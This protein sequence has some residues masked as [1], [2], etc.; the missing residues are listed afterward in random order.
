VTDQFKTRGP[1]IRAAI[2]TARG[3][4]LASLPEEMRKDVTDS[5]AKATAAFGLLDEVNKSTATVNI[6]AETY[7]PLHHHVRDIQDE[8][9]RNQAMVKKQKDEI[10]AI[11]PKAAD[12]DSRKKAFTAEIAALE[13]TNKKLKSSIPA[14][15]ESRHKTFRQLL[16]TDRRARLT[17]RRDVDSAYQP[18]I[19]AVVTI[20]GLSA[21]EA[22]KSELEGLRG[23]INSQPANKA[24]DTIETTLSK[25][26]AIP[27]ADKVR[28]ELY[29]ARRALTS[30]TPDKDEAITALNKTMSTYADEL[31]WRRKAAQDVLPGLKAYERAIH[32]TIGL[33]KQEKLPQ[34][35]VPPIAECTAYPRDISLYF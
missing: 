3:L 20:E 27:S 25:I 19:K 15:W 6:R 13:A 22:L 2:A 24:A 5:F 1:A 21:L 31:A 12:A 32:D 30:R 8:I 29:K 14:D 9:R 35:I 28:S 33:R 7:A 4:D 34:N 26:G 10:E 11:P 18:V 23:I 17:Y 16:T